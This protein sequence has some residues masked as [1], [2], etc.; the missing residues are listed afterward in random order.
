VLYTGGNPGQQNYG[1]ALR[2]ARRLGGEVTTESDGGA[3]LLATAGS[4]EETDDS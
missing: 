2:P 3:L 1:Y 4:I